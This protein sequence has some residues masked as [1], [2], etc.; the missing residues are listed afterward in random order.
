MK[1]CN[2][3]MQNQEILISIPKAAKRIGCSVPT[4]RT[5]IKEGHIPVLKVGK[6]LRIN[7]HTLGLFIAGSLKP[8]TKNR[9]RG[10][11]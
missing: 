7:R 6:R 4:F 2:S 5:M 11:R 10:A 3:L 1:N 9:A 8:D